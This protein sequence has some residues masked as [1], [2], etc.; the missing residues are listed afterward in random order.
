MPP[1]STVAPIPP[2]Q[3]IGP[4]LSLAAG[5]VAAAL[6]FIVTTVDSATRPGYDPWRHWVSHLALGDRAALATATL[7][8][9]GVL[10]A[11][12][13]HGLRRRLPAGRSA[14]WAERLVLSVG[15]ALLAAAAFPIDPGLGYPPGAAASHSVSGS[16]HDMAGAI[17]FASLTGAAALLGR[18]L[19]GTL[20]YA[21]P[22]GYLVA[23]VVAGSFVACSVLA[24]LD[25]AG[26]LPHAPSG[27]L[28]RVALFAGLGWLG[29]VGVHLR[30]TANP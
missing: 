6:L 18:S 28:E 15:V 25:F 12:Y 7:L 19:R 9:S 26:T 21:A 4:R 29:V 22:V 10:I 20:A 16:L 1:A 11:V 13:A 2:R 5:P 24:A 30:G 14:R 27:L 23:A 8:V 17:L 3:A